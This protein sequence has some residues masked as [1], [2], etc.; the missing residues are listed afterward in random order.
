M[1]YRMLKRIVRSWMFGI[2]HTPQGIGIRFGLC[3]SHNDALPAVLKFPSV[4]GKNWSGSRS[5]LLQTASIRRGFA[6]VEAKAGFM[7]VK[8]G[9][10]WLGS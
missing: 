7:L 3:R 10:G 6:V 2:S 5:R 1:T 8:N 9:S 4:T